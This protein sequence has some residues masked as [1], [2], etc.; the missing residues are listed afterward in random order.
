MFLGNIITEENLE[1]N[2]LFNITNSLD[3]IITGIPTLIV[4]WNLT[5]KLFDGRKMSIL[6]KQIDKDLFWTFTKKEKRV[7]FEQDYGI[8][9]K[10]SFKTLNDNVRY[11]YVNILTSRINEIKNI[12]K[13]IKSKEKCY[14]YIHNNS[15]IYIS[16]GETIF[17]VDINMIDFINI[18]RK[19]IYKL[20]Y[21]NANND[22]FFTNDFIDKNLKQNLIDNV[23]LIPHIKRIV[24]G[25]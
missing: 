6:E 16:D 25:N 3:G 23:K 10:N 4:G 20:F 12:L 24:D 8:F 11:E 17:G 22:L 1:S 2:K 13:K 7:D 14:I 18:E 21:S 19:K 9:I 5:K 15:F